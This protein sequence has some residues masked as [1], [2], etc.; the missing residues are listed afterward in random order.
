MECPICLRPQPSADNL[1]FNAHVDFCLS[2]SA[3]REAVQ[4]GGDN[5][6]GD[7]GENGSAGSTTGGTKKRPMM[8][9]FGNG[10]GKAVGSEKKGDAGKRK[11]VKRRRT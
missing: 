2:R 6:D 11:G 5:R 3:I 8:L 4:N 7:K 1:A 10:F 9:P